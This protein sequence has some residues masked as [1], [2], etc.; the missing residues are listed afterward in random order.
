MGS[1]ARYK[2]LAAA[3]HEF[4]HAFAVKTK[5]GE[6]HD[7]GIMLLVFTPI[8]YVD[9]SAASAFRKKRERILVGAAGLLVEFFFAALAFYVWLNVQPGPL[10]AVAYNV[11]LIAGVSSVLFNGNPLLRYDAY[12]IL[13]D[14]L[15][16]LR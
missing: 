14:L 10:R 4:G 1:H 9:A 8:P 15:E 13:V 6:V 16:I 5:G 2:V 11:M 3:I 7:M 12:Y